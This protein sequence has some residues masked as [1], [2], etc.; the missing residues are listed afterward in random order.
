MK[1][2]EFYLMELQSVNMIECGIIT[3]EIRK[4]KNLKKVKEV[5]ILDLAISLICSLETLKKI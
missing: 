4:E 1:L 2:I 3:L 5:Q